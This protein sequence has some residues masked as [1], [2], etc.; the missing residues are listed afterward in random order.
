MDIDN[1][2]WGGPLGSGGSCLGGA[3]ETHQNPKQIGSEEVQQKEKEEHLP[4]PGRRECLPVLW[5]P[6]LTHSPAFLF[7]LPRQLKSFPYQYPPFFSLLQALFSHFQSIV[8]SPIELLLEKRLCFPAQRSCL[9]LRTYDICAEGEWAGGE[10]DK[11]RVSTTA[12][13]FC[14]GERMFDPVFR[15]LIEHKLLRTALARNLM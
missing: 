7:S 6:F 2:A 8:R 10:G 5:I 14:L 12:V 9:L 3:K 13:V 15:T 1:R 4:L 11:E